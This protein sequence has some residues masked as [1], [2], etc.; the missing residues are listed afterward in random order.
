MGC[1]NEGRVFLLG[2]FWNTKD[3][4]FTSDTFFLSTPA[5]KRYG[6]VAIYDSTANIIN[7][8]SLKSKAQVNPECMQT[9]A[10]NN[11]YI[12]GHFRDSVDFDPSQ[13]EIHPAKP[14]QN[15]QCHICGL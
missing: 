5:L 12:A 15:V 10:A 1:D 8:F 2:S 14:N 4:D 13:N 7:A 6:F 3:F 9:D 11:I